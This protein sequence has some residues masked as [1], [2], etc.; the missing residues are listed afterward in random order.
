MRRFIRS[1]LQ[2]FGYDIVRFKAPY[3]RG[4]LN[5]EQILREFQWLQEYQ[6]NTIIDIG[7]NEGQFSDKIRMLF[8]EADIYAFEP[9]PGVFAKLKKNFSRDDHFFPLNLGLGDRA[10]QIEFRENE[11]SASSSFLV[12]GE[13][14]KRNF[15]EAV[16]S[17]TLTVN[18]ETLDRALSSA[19]IKDPMLV[20]LDVQGFE[21]KV[22]TGGQEILKNATMVIS[23]LSFTELYL[24]QPLFERIYDQLT[25][26]GFAYAGS[27]E[28]LRSPGNNKILQ[29]DGIFIKR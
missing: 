18:V 4:K 22:I 3:E 11:S 8:P 12:L 13:E 24:G 20:K 14:H 19:T 25:H 9:L 15:D 27:I 10:G 6:F 23:E 17:R 5:R 26:L 16:E 29:A 2:R 1:I 21:D 7:A 28:Q